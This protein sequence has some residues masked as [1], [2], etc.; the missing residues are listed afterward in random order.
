MGVW[1]DD[2]VTFAIH[3]QHPIWRSW[4]ALT[5]YMVIGLGG[6]FGWSR[7]H[8]RRVIEID[9]LAHAEEAHA[10]IARYEDDYQETLE[11]NEHLLRYRV[12]AAKRLVDLFSILL[13]AQKHSERTLDLEPLNILGRH[14][15]VIQTV[16]DLALRTVYHESVNLH[17]VFNE[18]AA[19]SEANSAAATQAIVLNDL[20]EDAIPLAHAE[21][22]CVVLHEALDL[23]STPFHLGPPT[24]VEPVVTFSLPPSIIDSNGGVRYRISVSDTRPPFLNSDDASIDLSTTWHIIETFGGSLKTKFDRGNTLLVELVLPAVSSPED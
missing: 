11:A 21:M 6:F 7:Y 22:L 2:E 13:G 18:L 24:T 19:Q 5:L 4:E 12:E 17:S 14:L 1:S 15:A 16:E 20:A 3:V 9:R 10:A 23:M 8:D